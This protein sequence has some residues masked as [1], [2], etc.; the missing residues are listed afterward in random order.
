MKHDNLDLAMALC[1]L[2]TQDIE[3]HDILE[4]DTELRR[5]FLSYGSETPENVQASEHIEY[6]TV[7]RLEYGRDQQLLGIMIKNKQILLSDLAG[8][9]ECM[10]MPDA[11]AEEFPELTQ[12][13]WH[14]FTRYMSMI[15][16]TLE[17]VKILS[18]PG[19]NQRER[20][21]NAQMRG[22]L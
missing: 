21:L 4:L 14:S 13:E 12:A 20:R 17:R 10:D 8:A 5:A 19:A 11:I 15:L 7:R 2:M 22:R 18:L 9:L 3:V 1:R 6:G 16:S